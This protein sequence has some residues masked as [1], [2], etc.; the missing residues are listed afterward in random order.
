ME[1]PNTV[2]S[3][4]FINKLLSTYSEATARRLSKIKEVNV[5]VSLASKPKSK[6][7]QV[8]I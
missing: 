6:V 1:C 5:E 2:I 7:E 3:S 8:A 4:Y